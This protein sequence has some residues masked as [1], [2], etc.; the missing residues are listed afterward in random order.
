MP[1]LSKAAVGGL[2]SLLLAANAPLAVVAPG[3]AAGPT[4]AQTGPTTAWDQ[5]VLSSPTTVTITDANRNLVLS[6]FQDYVL[7]CPVGA[8]DLSGKI[9]VWGGRNVVFQSCYEYVTNPNGD[10]ACI[11]GVRI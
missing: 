1:S 4:A 11:L 9:T 7:R 3:A 5:P 2:L 10:W 6:P 8:D